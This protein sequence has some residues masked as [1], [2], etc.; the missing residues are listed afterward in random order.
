MIFFEAS[1]S[2]QRIAN[3]R[4]FNPIGVYPSGLVGKSLLGI[5]DNI[6]PFITQ[7]ATGQRKELNIFGND[8]PT[9]DGSGIRDCNHVM[10]LA[11]GHIPAFDYLCNEEPQ[12][13][14]LNL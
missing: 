2:K 4:Y 13:L 8:W 7:V 9:P 14:N 12:I 11:D 1:K 6:F 3:L 5:L 10:D